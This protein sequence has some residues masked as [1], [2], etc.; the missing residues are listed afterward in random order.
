MA[1]LRRW[2]WIFDPERFEQ[3]WI[4][5]PSINHVNHGLASCANFLVF[6]LWINFFSLPYDYGWAMRLS[7][8]EP[9]SL[10]RHPYFVSIF[11]LHILLILTIRN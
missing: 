5:K 9:P 6:F 7:L 8:I 3:D 4:C 11:T 2:G 10:S 1:D